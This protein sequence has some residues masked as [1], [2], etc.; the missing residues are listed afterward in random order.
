VVKQKGT[1]TVSVAVPFFAKILPLPGSVENLY[2]FLGV[3]MSTVDVAKSALLEP[4]G[5]TIVFFTRDVVV[6]FIEKFDGAMETAGPVEMS[7]HGR[8]VVEILAI[9]D[10]GFLDFVDSVVDFVDG[11][12]FLFTKFAMIGAIEMGAS[13]A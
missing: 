9:I 11:L 3:V 6:S 2:G 4:L 5:E 12:L 10:S 1:A 7:V 13:V 8:M